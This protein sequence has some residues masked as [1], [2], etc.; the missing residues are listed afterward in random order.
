MK[1]PERIYHVS[2]T[3]LS[4]ARFAG[5]CTF[6]GTYYVY[7]PME[8]MLIRDDILIAEQKKIREAEAAERQ[9]KA[10]LQLSL[11]SYNTSAV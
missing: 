2:K 10:A 7:N 8:D 11:F 4:V 9:R 3:Q 5:G 1:G 6:N